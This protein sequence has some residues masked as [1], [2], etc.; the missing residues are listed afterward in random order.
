MRFLAGETSRALALSLSRSLLPHKTKNLPLALSARENSWARLVPKSTQ[1]PTKREL[2]ESGHLWEGVPWVTEVFSRVW[3][4]ASSAAGRQV[5]GRRHEWRSREKKLFAWLTF[6]YLTETGN[7]AWKACGTQGREGG[8]QSWNGKI[9]IIIIIIST[10]SLSICFLIAYFHA[11]II[12]GNQLAGRPFFEYPPTKKCW[13]PA[14]NQK[15]QRSGF[16]LICSVD[17]FD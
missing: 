7:R 17:S 11:N 3:W 6:Q 16:R 14:G 9:I 15:S 12:V 8:D 2:W 10:L 4:G 13:R 1:R 5:F